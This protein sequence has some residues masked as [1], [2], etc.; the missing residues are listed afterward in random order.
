MSTMVSTDQKSKMRLVDSGTRRDLIVLLYET[1]QPLRGY[2]KMHIAAKRLQDMLEKE[3]GYT[4]GYDFENGARSSIH[5]V[6]DEQFQAD[7]ER[8][9][10]V[11]KVVNN[12]D[13][14]IR[15]DLAGYYTHTLQVEGRPMGEYLLKTDIRI[16][17]KKNIDDP[18]VLQEK[19][20]RAVK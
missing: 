9:D 14:L 2:G 8:Y 19:I 11:G 18:D 12:S 16:N 5:S 15:E 17:L 7:I 6:W 10:A 4:L 20:R 3:Y 1:V 13:D